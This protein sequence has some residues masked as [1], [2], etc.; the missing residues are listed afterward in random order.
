ME[1]FSS[2]NKFPWGHSTREKWKMKPSNT[3][4]HRSTYKTV[5]ENN[6]SFV[7]AKSKCGKSWRNKQKVIKTRGKDKRAER[8]SQHELHFH[9]RKSYSEWS[10]K[11]SEN[12]TMKWKVYWKNKLHCSVDAIE[13]STCSR[14]RKR[15]RQHEAGG[16]GKVCRKYKDKAN[17]FW[18][19]N[20]I[21]NIKKGSLQRQHD[22][23]DNVECRQFVNI[24]WPFLSCLNI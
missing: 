17:I 12:E 20:R 9:Y 3:K 2:E 6:S 13:D 16:N 11:N 14:V 18:N 7:I 21:K 19:R 22:R 23:H 10:E 5:C 24:N 4:H 15:T 8:R 1:S